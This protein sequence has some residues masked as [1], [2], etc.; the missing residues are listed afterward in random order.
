MKKHTIKFIKQETKKI[1]ENCICISKSYINSKTNLKFK[2]DK[3]HKFEMSW[4]NFRIGKGCK[5]C[6]KIEIYN[7]Q[8][9]NINLIKD[10]TKKLAE[11]YECLSEEYTNN[12][13][14]LLFKCNNNHKYYATW[15]KFNGGGRCP[16]CSKYHIRYSIKE[17]KEITKNIA[18]GYKCLSNSYKRSDE[19]LKFECNNNHIFYMTWKNFKNLSRRCPICY[20][21]NNKGENHPMWKGGISCEP[22]CDVWADKEYKES[23]KERDNYECQN[24]DC[25]KTS[26][27]LC[28]HHIN[29][30]KK[31]CR[32]INLIT[33]CQSCNSRANKNKDFWKKY[34]R[35]KVK[36]IYEI[37]SRKI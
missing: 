17:V 3:G 29:Y 1:H 10:K 22:Y 2:C 7:N 11:G 4:N 18:K 32:P 30:V 13:I 8:R 21:E 19:K 34:Y 36:G 12:N 9:Y 16:K 5:I 6:T 25:W 14:K 26:K 23:I 33:V 24:E 20:L 37:H 35:R 28:L 31:D 15:N 27:K